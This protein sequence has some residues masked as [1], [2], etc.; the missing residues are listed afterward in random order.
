MFFQPF[1]VGLPTFP[2]GQQA[3]AALSP[4]P[5]KKSPDDWSTTLF[6]CKKTLLLQFFLWVSTLFHFLA[7]VLALS[8]YNQDSQIDANYAISGRV[9]V[10]PSKSSY[11]K[12]AVFGCI[13]ILTNGLAIIGLLKK[14]RVFLIPNIL[15]LAC[16]LILDGILALVYL[17]STTSNDPDFHSGSDIADISSSVLSPSVQNSSKLMFPSIIIKI[18]FTAII[19]RCLMDVYQRDMSLRSSRSP[20]RSQTK[21]K[22]ARAEEGEASPIKSPKLGKYSRFQ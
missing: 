19:F 10:T 13:G 22:E 20:F 18:V 14:Q 3:Q 1:H 6:C 9:V 12:L 8:T 7:V 17:T 5:T 16:T 2:N 11:E 15:F 4:E 21:P